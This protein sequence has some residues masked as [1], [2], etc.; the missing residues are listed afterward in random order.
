MHKYK[1]DL[2]FLKE[3]YFWLP[4]FFLVHS[5]D[6]FASINELQL[7]LK[8]QTLQKWNYGFVTDASKRV[9]SQPE[10]RIGVSFEKWKKI[11]NNLYLIHSP[12]PLG[13]GKVFN[14]KNG[15]SYVSWHLGY[16]FIDD[17]Y[18]ITPTLNFKSHSSIYNSKN[19]RIQPSLYYSV[20]IPT[21]RIDLGF[22]SRFEILFSHHWT[23]KLRVNWGPE[24]SLGSRY[25][26][27]L[28]IQEGDSGTQTTAGDFS[29]LVGPGWYLSDS[30]VRLDLKASYKEYS[31]NQGLSK[32]QLSNFS[33]GIRLS[34][35]STL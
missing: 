3:A 16:T 33:V 31:Q 12:F 8:D 10:Y 30:I 21:S 9:S 11:D 18:N 15:P 22:L 19:L 25:L 17:Q 20:L 32:D 2:K 26:S 34:Y 1:F 4:F 28:F 27:N 35:H 5:V 29:L 6:S 23:N 14:T 7:N 13:L 24:V